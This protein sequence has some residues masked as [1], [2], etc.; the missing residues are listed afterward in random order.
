MSYAT[1]AAISRATAIGLDLSLA[2]WRDI[3]LAITDTMAGEEPLAKH[4]M[5]SFIGNVRDGGERWHIKI[6]G[7]LFD[8]IYDPK[9]ARI[10]LV[11]RSKDGDAQTA[12]LPKST[13]PLR[14]TS[15]ERVLTDAG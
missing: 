14:G 13:P 11:I 12:V 9:L 10:V 1:P 6:P 7:R 4:A 3:F 8:V 5:A 15:A 2:G